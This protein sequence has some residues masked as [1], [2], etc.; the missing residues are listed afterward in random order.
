MVPEEHA[1]AGAG[2]ADDQ[3]VTYVADVRMVAKRCAPAG[4]GVEEGRGVRRI[5]RAGIGFETGPYGG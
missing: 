1:L 4:G 5:H 2:R 3:A